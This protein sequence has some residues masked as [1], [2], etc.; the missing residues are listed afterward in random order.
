MPPKYNF[1]GSPRSARNPSEFSDTR[2]PPQPWV[3]RYSERVNPG[4]R[5]YFNL[6]THQSQWEFPLEEFTQDVVSRPPQPL[7]N[8]LLAEP[9]LDTSKLSK[10][11][12]SLRDLLLRRVAEPEPP[13]SMRDL[14]V[15]E[16]ELPSETHDVFARDILERE[17]R[18]NIFRRMARD[19]YPDASE[20]QSALVAFGPWNIR[21]A[22][23]NT[24]NVD[25]LKI[26]YRIL[27]DM[28]RPDRNSRHEDIIMKE[29]PDSD[30]D[31]DLDSDNKLDVWAKG[32][33][34]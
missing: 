28:E 1:V 9:E 14:R 15:A 11:P 34:I 13:K 16:P 10:L 2:R 23:R 3:V 29:P 30:S 20:D 31:S 12:K 32:F 5:Y 19:A 6:R 4:I 25:E 27:A 7:G 33:Y 24:T 26:L 8:L 22:I 21:N 18:S 17:L